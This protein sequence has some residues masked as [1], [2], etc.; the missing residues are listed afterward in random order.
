MLMHLSLPNEHKDESNNLNL[1]MIS[2]VSFNSEAQAQ[3]Q[4]YQQLRKLGC[5][6]GHIIGILSANGLYIHRF[7]AQ[8]EIWQ[9]TADRDK[10]S[11]LDKKHIATLIPHYIQSALRKKMEL[12][13]LKQQ[14]LQN[15]RLPISC[16]RVLLCMDSTCILKS[17]IGGSQ[18]LWTDQFE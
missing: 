18:R 6:W 15:L 2:F 11:Q 14:Y 8:G 4:L 5:Q 10:N 3:F 1:C 7:Q 12:N 16:K 17:D 9:H 13:L